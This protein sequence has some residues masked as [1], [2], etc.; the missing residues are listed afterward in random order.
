MPEPAG[1]PIEAKYARL[2]DHYDPRAGTRS[3]SPRPARGDT[4]SPVFSLP[5]R[6]QASE[7]LRV[8]LTPEQLYW[9]R[10]AAARAGSKIDESAIIGAGIALLERLPIDWRRI[11]SRTDLAQALTRAFE[12]EP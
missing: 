1:P 12:R 3:H 5:R 4:Q 8:R 7:S 9:V 11:T 6:R 10:L 2:L